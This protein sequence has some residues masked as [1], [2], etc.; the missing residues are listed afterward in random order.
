MFGFFFKAFDASVYSASTI[1]RWVVIQLLLLR[2]KHTENPHSQTLKCAELA[3]GRDLPEH[4]LALCLCAGDPDCAGSGCPP[5]HPVQSEVSPAA[6]N[7]PG[8]DE[9]GRHIKT[10]GREKTKGAQRE[11]GNYDTLPIKQLHIPFSIHWIIQ[12]PSSLC[13]GLC[14]AAP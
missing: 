1:I 5:L 7:Q 10:E 2:G 14:A 12:S 4:F 8:T 9:P 11:M 13:R 3:V 6:I